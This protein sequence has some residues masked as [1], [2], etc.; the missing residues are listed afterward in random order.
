MQVLAIAASTLDRGKARVSPASIPSKCSHSDW[1]QLSFLGRNVRGRGIGTGAWWRLLLCWGSP[2]KLST[3]A[4]QFSIYCSLC[5]MTW[6]VKVVC[7]L[8]SGVSVLCSHLRSPT[9]EKA[10]APHSSTLAWKIPWTEEPGRLQSMGSR[11]VGHYWAT[12]LSRIGE[13]NG[14]TLQ[15]SCLENPKDRGAWLAAVC[16]I[17]QSRTWLKRLSS[18][19]SSKKPHSVVK[20]LPAIQETQ[21]WY[22]SW[23]DLME[24]GMETQSGILAW[25]IPRI[26]E[27]GGLRSMGSQ[28]VIH[29]WSDHAH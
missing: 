19:S 27:P 4:R 24:K 18:S 29:N 23:E 13:G 10:M 7:I 6:S 20:K 2:G 21:I 3:N 5:A 9:L 22:L 12:S 28:R 15:C 25:E 14:N 16:G 26:E 17:T 11:R 8:K 1:Q